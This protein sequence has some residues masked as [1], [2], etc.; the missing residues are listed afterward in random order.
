M[1]GLGG[2]KRSPYYELM[3]AVEADVRNNTPESAANVL[4]AREAYL[5]DRRR[6]A[7]RIRVQH[8]VSQRMYLLTREQEEPEVKPKGHNP[9]PLIVMAVVAAVLFVSALAAVLS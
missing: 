7:D 9:V 3:N 4:A 1:A 5:E 8:E 2:S 6:T